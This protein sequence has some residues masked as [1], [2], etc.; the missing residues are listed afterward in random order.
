VLVDRLAGV[1]VAT[2]RQAAVT[3]FLHGV[4]SNGATQLSG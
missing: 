2:D 4:C 1:V 3:M